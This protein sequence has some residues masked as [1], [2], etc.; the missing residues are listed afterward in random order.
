MAY[1][2]TPN[3]DVLRGKYSPLQEE[4]VADCTV[5]VHCENDER[6]VKKTCEDKAC[7]SVDICERNTV[8]KETAF[9]NPAYVP[10]MDLLGAYQ[11]TTEL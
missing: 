9:E 1:Q 11:L 8:D 10:A 3:D 6:K 5:V 2:E 7:E 4:S